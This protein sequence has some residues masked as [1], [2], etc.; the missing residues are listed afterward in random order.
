LDDCYKNSRSISVSHFDSDL[1]SIKW[2]ARLNN[3]GQDRMNR[4][5]KECLLDQ[6]TE[7]QLPRCELCLT[8]TTTA[9]LFGK[10]SRASSPLELIQSDVCGP[11][12]VK[13]HVH[14]WA[15]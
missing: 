3:I 8:G 12:N 2:H 4:L 9:K 10:A 13:A 1:E 7:V 14:H 5:A 11:M 6:L 15:F